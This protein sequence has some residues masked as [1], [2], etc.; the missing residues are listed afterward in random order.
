MREQAFQG[1]DQKLG[2]L[3]GWSESKP[4]RPKVAKSNG[5]AIR[6]MQLPNGVSGV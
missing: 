1:E 2:H 4:C 6:D 5:S 3:F